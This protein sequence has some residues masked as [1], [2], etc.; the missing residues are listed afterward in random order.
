M[1]RLTIIA[2][3]LFALPV[4]PA[5]GEPCENGAAAPAMAAAASSLVVPSANKFAA[6][7]LL[8]CFSLLM[9]SFATAAD[10]QLNRVMRVAPTIGVRIPASAPCS[11]SVCIR[12][13]Q[14]NG[15]PLVRVCES[16]CVE[17]C[18]SR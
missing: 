8:A 4:V 16:L 15:G 11:S 7:A 12:D 13:C 10:L 3:S 18:R 6:A 2:V 14:R 5:M 9:P 1:R 17:T